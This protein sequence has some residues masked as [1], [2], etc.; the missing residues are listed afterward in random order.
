MVQISAKFHADKTLTLKSNAVHEA[1]QKK[2]SETFGDYGLAAIKAGFSAK[3]INE[4]TRI[5]MMKIR[6]GPHQ[7]LLKAIPLINDIGNKLVSTKILYVGATMKHCFAF[8]KVR[9]RNPS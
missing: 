6:H 1:I 4:Q 3:Y 7:F 9:R 2:V 8:I 5:V